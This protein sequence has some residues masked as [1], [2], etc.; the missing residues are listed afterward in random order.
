MKDLTVFM[1]VGG[2]ASLIAFSL[3]FPGTIPFGVKTKPK[4]LTSVFRKK[5]FVQ[6]DFHAIFLQP[7][8][9][10]FL[11]FQLLIMRFGVDEN[12]V[13]ID[14]NVFDV[15]KNHFHHALK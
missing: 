1:S 3:S 9:Y 4:K 13:N 10:C 2:L 11:G 12:V 5:T 6:V 14:Y 8:K 7:L 15:V